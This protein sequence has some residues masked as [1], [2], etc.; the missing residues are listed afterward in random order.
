[1]DHCCYVDFC[2]VDFS[3]SDEQIYFLKIKSLIVLE[4]CC[5][6]TDEMNYYVI[7]GLLIW[8]TDDNNLQILTSL[9]QIAALAD[10]PFT[11][12][13]MNSSLI[14]SSLENADLKTLLM[15]S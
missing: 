11:A 4:G 2:T 7:S 9:D 15:V 6:K 12:E 10:A 3:F 13:T 1:M 8:F 14:N 5:L